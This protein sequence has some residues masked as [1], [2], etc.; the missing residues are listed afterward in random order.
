MDPSRVVRVVLQNGLVDCRVGNGLHVALKELSSNF[1]VI[2]INGKAPHNR[3]VVLS[4]LE[5]GN[6][7]AIEF[8]I[9]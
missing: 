8:D 4:R 1:K 9:L 2:V 6:Y 7:L 5:N 3:V